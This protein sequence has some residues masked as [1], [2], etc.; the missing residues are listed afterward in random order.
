M[1]KLIS[2]GLMI[3]MLLAMGAGFADQ[4]D[5][6]LHIIAILADERAAFADGM[7]KEKYPEIEISYVT[8][9]NSREIIANLFAGDP[10]LDIIAFC[11]HEGFSPQYAAF[12]GAMVDL[13]QY[14]GIAE[15]AEDY[16]DS[17]VERFMYD[18]E[19]FAIPYS[20]EPYLWYANPQLFDEMGID[21]PE[22]TWTW[23]DYF[24]LGEAVYEY[25]IE[26]GTD[27]LLMYCALQYYPLIQ[28]AANTVDYANGTHE[29]G[30][31]SFRELV[32]KW[33]HLFDIGVV[34]SR[35]THDFSS[36][37]FNQYHFDSHAKADAL[38]SVKQPNTMRSS[39]IIV[40]PDEIISET[41]AF[42]L[43]MPPAVEGMRRGV[44]AGRSIGIAKTSTMKEEAAYWLYSYMSYETPEIQKTEIF[45]IPHCIGNGGVMFKNDA[46][47]QYAREWVT[48]EDS[49]LLENLDHWE[50][51]VQDSAMEYYNDL[52]WAVTYNYWNQLVAGE[53][54][55]DEYID[56]CVKL[57]DQYLGE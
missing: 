50:K 11:E 28:F 6:T 22:D 19:L 15:R 39:E 35:W 12:N 45:T 32:E 30:S 54:T 37:E 24:E 20:C 42:R 36:I 56:M 38:L 16:Y 57:A 2:V 23:E 21:L 1:K 5:N 4:D 31:E 55:E 49:W 48:V 43:V 44:D 10:T 51:Y 52:T 47:M 13:L 40:E 18:G 7:L 41:C 29:F 9:T 27:Y 17:F 14:D 3:A 8:E 33:K 34:A 26:N 53:I 25:N 46:W